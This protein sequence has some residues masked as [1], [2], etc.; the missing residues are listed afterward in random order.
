[1]DEAEFLE[2]WYDRMGLPEIDVLD[3]EEAAAA[4]LD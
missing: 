2:W 1:M 3:A 4:Y